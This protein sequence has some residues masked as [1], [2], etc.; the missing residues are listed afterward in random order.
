MFV[1][2]YYCVVA[3]TTLEISVEENH[4]LECLWAWKAVDMLFQILVDCDDRV[5]VVGWQLFPSLH[6]L[7]RPFV[8]PT[9][10]LSFQPEG[11]TS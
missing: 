5:L 10:Q 8:R 1:H 6:A 4:S 2:L 11:A 9:N 3:A 7:E